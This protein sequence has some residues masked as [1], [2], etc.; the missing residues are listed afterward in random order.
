MSVLPARFPRATLRSLGEAHQLC[1]RDCVRFHNEGR[2]M[3]PMDF[4][5]SVN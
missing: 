2:A 4:A 1:D 3:P 5:V